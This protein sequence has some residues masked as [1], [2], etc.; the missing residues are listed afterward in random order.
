MDPRVIPVGM[1][2]LR[3]SDSAETALVTYSLGSC[4]GLTAY[5][6]AVRLG[7]MAHIMLPGGNGSGDEEGKYAS[8]CVP[9]MIEGMLRRGAQ[10]SRIVIKMAGGAKILQFSGAPDGSSIGSQNQAAVKRELER[11]GLKVAASDCGGNFGR[12]VRLLLDTGVVEILT[13]TRGQWTI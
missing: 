2:E 1:G 8:S 7:A 3:F 5:D 13:A 4:I 10:K 12:T 6:P 11:L 9:A